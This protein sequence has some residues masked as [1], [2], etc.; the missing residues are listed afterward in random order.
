MINKLE[1]VIFGNSN[2]SFFAESEKGDVVIINENT[3]IAGCKF[4]YLSVGDEL[5]C[6][7][8]TS[9]RSRLLEKPSQ[10]LKPK[11][12]ELKYLE[13]KW[14]EILK[15][16]K[17][18]S[19]DH[20]LDIKDSMIRPEIIK[21]TFIKNGMLNYE[22]FQQLIDNKK[23]KNTTH[24]KIIELH[25]KGMSTREISEKV[26]NCSHMTCARILK[27]YEGYDR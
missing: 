8:L 6:F 16:D 1:V 18:Y 13:N 15:Q 20:S 14:N 4:E 21:P 25:L 23:I 5:I 26:K 22:H 19:I 11:R 10:Y 27:K 12:V 9:I 17:K 3:N 24:K 7:N 2:K